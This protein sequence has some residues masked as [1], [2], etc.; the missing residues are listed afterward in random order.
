MPLMRCHCVNIIAETSHHITVNGPG[1]TAVYTQAL[2]SIT[3]LNT[4]DEPTKYP[5]RRIEIQVFDGGFV[6]D[7]VTGFINISLVGDNPLMLTCGGS[8]RMFTEE[9]PTPLS[10]ANTLSI[11]DLDQ[12]QMIESATVSLENAQDGDEIEVSMSV[13]GG[14]TVQQSSSVSIMISGNALAAEYQVRN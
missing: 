2:Q 4:A 11:S 10:I 13:S 5:P 9:S 1:S 6:S 3:Y 12:N 8:M 14:L 7:V